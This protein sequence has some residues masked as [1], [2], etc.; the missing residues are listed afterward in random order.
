M[1]IKKF[2]GLKNT[3]SPERLEPGYLAVAQN[4]DIDDT[5]RILTRKG[6][7][8]LLAGG[9]HSLWVDGD[10]ALVVNA[11]NDLCRLNGNFT[12][13]ALTRMSSAARVSYNRQG[14]TVYVSNGTDILRLQNGAPLKWGTLPPLTPGRA[15]P[16]AGSLPAGRY[17]YRLTYVRASGAESGAS[18]LGVVE[19]ASPGGISFSE[20]PS[21]D[22]PEVAA[23]YIYLST[24]N[25]TELF[26]AAAVPAATASYAYLGGSQDLTA[27]LETENDVPPLAGHIVEWHAGLMYVVRG[28]TAYYSHPYRYE[29]FDLVRRYFSFPGRITLFA[30]V[31]DGVFLATAERTWFLAGRDPAQMQVADV[32]NYGAIEGTAAKTEVGKVKALSEAQEGEPSGMAVMW[33]TS[34][35]VCVGTDG[36][37]AINMTEREFSFPSAQRGAGLVRQVRGYTQYLSILEGTGVAANPS[38]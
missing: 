35:G 31:N 6:V 1:E 13:T 15:A 12:T 4:V 32:F 17:L 19:L 33:T 9:Y 23:K 26:R 8:S 25:G 2:K 29:S 7:T 27:R 18:D 30:A 21:S 28:G 16:G 3:T 34:H 11:T 20:L 37:R 36:G 5:S 10:T 22:D 24:P 14:G 38:S